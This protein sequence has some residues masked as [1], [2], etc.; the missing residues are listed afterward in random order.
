V[1]KRLADG[2]PDRQKLESK[3][4]QEGPRTDVPKRPVSAG[5]INRE[6]TVLKRMFSLAIQA[7]KLVHKP[8]FPMMRENNVRAGFFEREQYL[9]VRG[10][11]KGKYRG[12]RADMAFL[13]TRI[14]VKR[15]ALW[16]AVAAHASPVPNEL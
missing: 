16:Q 7:G 12:Q 6:L 13:D 3:R 14:W 4:K 15:H 5:E 9:S 1:T 10:I 2:T 11:A 8:H